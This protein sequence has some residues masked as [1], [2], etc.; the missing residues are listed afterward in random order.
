M[1]HPNIINEFM[2]SQERNA[3]VAANTDAVALSNRAGAAMQQGRYQEAAALH[4]QALALKLRAYPESSIQ[5]GI[6]LNGLGEALTRSGELEDAEKALLKAL[7]TRESGGPRIDAAVTR[8]NVG[9]LREAQGRFEDA[10]EVRLRGAQKREMMC[11]FYNCPNNKMFP[12]NSLSACAKCKAVFYCSKGC[13]G[14][15]WAARHKPLCQANETATAATAA[16]AA[17]TSG[18]QSAENTAA[19]KGEQ[20]AEGNAAS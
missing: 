4:A 5:A 7:A 2:S 18:A 14:K 11:G 12:L 16:A 9:A 13:Q 20:T 6:S 1:Y 19:T 17:S 10:R 15:D 3:V 8:D